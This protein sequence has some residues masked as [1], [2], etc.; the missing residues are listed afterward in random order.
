MMERYLMSQSRKE[1]QKSMKS[2]DS[3]QTIMARVLVWSDKNK[4]IIIMTCIPIVLMLAGWSGWDYWQQ[5]QDKKLTESLG[6]VEIL[7]QNELATSQKVIAAFKEQ[8]AS[9]DEKLAG[10]KKSGAKKSLNEQKKK[11]EQQIKSVKSEHSKSLQQF[12]VFFTT[13]KSKPQGWVAGFRAAGIHIESRSF[14]DARAVLEDLKDAA[15]SNPFYNSLATI[16]LVNVTEELGDLDAALQYCDS[17]I[18]TV[19]DKMMAKILFSKA[20]ILMSMNKKEEAEK[21][22][23]ELNEKFATS[24]EADKARTLK[25]LMMR[26]S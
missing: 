14:K 7:F 11:I 9:L 25:A 18:L 19:D 23:A 6:E 20:R 17:L 22:I 2:P 3:F 12:V 26:A 24:A 15:S 16:T 5:E 10:A 4:R 1:F 8:V 13:N 21:V